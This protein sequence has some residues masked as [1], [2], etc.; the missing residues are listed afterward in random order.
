MFCHEFIVTELGTLNGILGVD[1]LESNDV[2]LYLSRGILVLGDQSIQ[3]ERETAP[4]CATVK[5]A[6][7]IVAPPPLIVN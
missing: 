1:F 7:N 5:V 4:V 6:K 3:L 2:T